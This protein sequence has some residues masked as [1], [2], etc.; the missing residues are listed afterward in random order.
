MRKIKF[1]GVLAALFA[2]SIS[3]TSCNRSDDP[4]GKNKITDIKVPKS[5]V[6]ATSNVS[7]KYSIDAAAT[8]DFAADG[9][10]AIFR[11]IESKTVKVTAE[12]TGADADKYV[13]AK[14]TATV[15]FSSK[16]YGVP[17]NFVFVEKS[18]PVAQAVAIGGAPVVNKDQAV[19]VASITVPEGTTVSGSTEGFA[20]TAYKTPANI[21]AD[22]AKADKVKAGGYVLS[23]QPDGAKFDKPVTLKVFVG[24]GLAGLP[25]TLESGNESVE[26]K[27]DADGTVS[28]KVSHFSDWILKLP[29]KTLSEPTS[30]SDLI[31]PIQTIN[32]VSG[33]N[34]FSYTKKI[35]FD[36]DLVQGN[37]KAFQFICDVLQSIYGDFNSSLTE[38]ASFTVDGAGIANVSVFQ[39]KSKVKMSDLDD[40]FIFDVTRYE[41]VDYQIMINGVAHSGGSGK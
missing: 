30:F 7:A 4:V 12:Y 29:L 35:G 28:F 2:V 15:N 3:L 16:P 23:C 36:V 18:V 13:N 22:I 33:E 5:S 19:T 6:L 39:N 41:G 32:A 24:E 1:L 25:L 38:E 34:K 37:A 9:K 10:K 26:G 27:V 20:I 17:I 31:P 14:Q 8:S 40:M 21:L 11:D